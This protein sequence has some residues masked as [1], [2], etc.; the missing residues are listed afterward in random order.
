VVLVVLVVVVLEVTLEMEQQEQLIL[1]VEVVGARGGYTS[2]AGGKGV[3]ILS[4]PL[5]SFSG[6]TTGSPTESDDGTT[7][8]LVF[9][10]D[11]SYTA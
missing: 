2:G 4:M 11:G 1:V 5:A 6:T 9:N 8:V 10:G 7:K 3:V